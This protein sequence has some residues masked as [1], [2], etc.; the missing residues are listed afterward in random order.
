MGWWELNLI[1][2]GEFCFA[3]RSIEIFGNR[4]WRKTL[5]G[6]WLRSPPPCRS[7]RVEWLFRPLF[8]YSR[9]DDG[10]LFSDRAYFSLHVPFALGFPPASCRACTFFLRGNARRKSE[11]G[12]LR[13][14]LPNSV[15][16][17]STTRLCNRGRNLFGLTFEAL[18][19]WKLH[20]TYYY[21]VLLLLSIRNRPR[22]LDSE[23]G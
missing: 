9:C 6:W 5:Y 11:S 2:P 16:M 15:R 17:V 19:G 8:G 14:P 13:I 18:L 1:D 12:S 4:S 10:G 7:R 22:Y 20:Y 21:C 3:Q 23:W